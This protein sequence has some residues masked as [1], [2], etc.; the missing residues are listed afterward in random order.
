MIWVILI[1]NNLVSINCFKNVYIGALGSKYNS[2]YNIVV[3]REA[4]VDGCS[5]PGSLGDGQRQVLLCP[6]E[7][8]A[9]GDRTGPATEVSRIF[10]TPL[11]CVLCMNLQKAESHM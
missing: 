9:P 5:P 11:G 8:P 10:F 3:E 6:W 2:R 7:D 1:I 4:C